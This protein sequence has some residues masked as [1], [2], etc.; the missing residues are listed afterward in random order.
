MMSQ[1]FSSEVRISGAI[2]KRFQ[3]VKSTFCAWQFLQSIRYIFLFT[4]KNPEKYDEVIV[5]I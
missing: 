4:Y 2:A 3:H 5:T 1:T